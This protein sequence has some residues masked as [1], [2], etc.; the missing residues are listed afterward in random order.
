[1]MIENVYADGICKTKKPL[2]SKNK[3]P[4]IKTTIYDI[5]FIDFPVASLLDELG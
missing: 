1:M 2:G 3:K 5:S 4:Y